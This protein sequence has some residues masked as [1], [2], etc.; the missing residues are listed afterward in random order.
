MIKE[1]VRDT[2]EASRKIVKNPLMRRAMLCA[3]LLTLPACSPK[4]QSWVSGASISVGSIPED[5]CVVN[6]KQLILGVSTESD[7][8]MNL[9]YVRKD[10]N[11]V[12][13]HFATTYSSLGTSYGEQ[14]EFVF[15]G[16]PENCPQ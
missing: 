16:K 1:I 9:T 11:I 12:L 14:G 2:V 4:M 5:V 10:G 3:S 6:G 8:D 15:R 7:G 13:K